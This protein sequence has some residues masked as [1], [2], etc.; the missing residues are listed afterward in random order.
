M[1]IPIL[2]QRV[3][4]DKA[5]AVGNRDLERVERRDRRDDGPVD[6]L[7]DEEVLVLR[8]REMLPERGLD[9]VLLAGEVGAHGPQHLPVHVEEL[10]E[11]VHVGDRVGD[12]GL[13]RR[14]LRVRRILHRRVIRLACRR[15]NRGSRGRRSHLGDIAGDDVCDGID[16]VGLCHRDVG[17]WIRRLSRASLRPRGRGARLL[18]LAHGNVGVCIRSARSV[19]GIGGQVHAGRGFAIVGALRVVRLPDRVRLVVHGVGVRGRIR[20]GEVLGVGCG[21]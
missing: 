18:R 17:R 21:G 6:P 8:P 14:G 1:R 16:V 20:H 15:W 11:V 2:A 4:H 10:D 13:W 12:L 3:P 19:R 7:P 5:R 9:V